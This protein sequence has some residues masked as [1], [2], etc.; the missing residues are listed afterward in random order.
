MEPRIEPWLKITLYYF[1]IGISWIVLTD[2][3]SSHYFHSTEYYGIVQ[4]YKGLV[5]VTVT[6][7]FLFLI[8][9]LEFTKRRHLENQLIA[10]EERYRQ[11]VDT[12]QEGILLFDTESR[13]ILCNNK[14]REM[15]NIGR[16]SI[17]NISLSDIF[18][19]PSGSKTTVDMITVFTKQSP[20]EMVL[21]QQGEKPVSRWVLVSAN[22]VRGKETLIGYL[23]LVTDIHERKLAEEALQK[24]NSENQVLMAGIHHRVKN[25]LQIISSILNLQENFPSENPHQLLQACQL[26]ILSMAMIHEQLYRS[27]QYSE[28]SLSE[29]I[30]DMIDSIQGMFPYEESRI[31]IHVEVE[32]THLSLD[33]AIPVGIILNEILTNSYKHA[34]PEANSGNIN[35]VGSRMED[36]LEVIVSDNGIGFPAASLP[37]GNL[38]MTIIDALV[39]QIHGEYHINGENGYSFSMKFPLEKKVSTILTDEAS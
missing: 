30:G 18:S 5:Y 15:L 4:T 34:F 16:D 9:R 14:A 13:L 19:F 23:S 29:Y 25:N 39:K 17:Q 22:E 37:E 2:Q 31:T 3:F 24:V 1:I 27:E 36:F 26:R 28:I 6:A 12:A 10:S 35:I 7:F 32:K 8:L 38:G 33:K 20:M 11:S 21:R